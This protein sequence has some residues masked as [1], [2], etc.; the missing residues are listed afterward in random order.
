[1]YSLVTYRRFAGKHDKKNYDFIE[2]DRRSTV[3]LII[4]A[5]IVLPVF[6]SVSPSVANNTSLRSQFLYRLLAIRQGGM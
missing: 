6:N 3:V 5:F 1:M 4:T 2:I